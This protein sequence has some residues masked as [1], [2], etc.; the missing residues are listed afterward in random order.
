MQIGIARAT[1]MGGALALGAVLAAPATTPAHA[2]G[3]EKAKGLG[4]KVDWING[5]TLDKFE[6]LRGRVILIE[7]WGIN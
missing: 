4:E 2:D 7:L 1:A 6:D 3:G 5:P